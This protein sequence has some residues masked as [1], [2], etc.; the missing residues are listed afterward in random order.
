M[1]SSLVYLWDQ[2]T[3][4]TVWNT[5]ETGDIYSYFAGFSYTP[6]KWEGRAGQIQKWLGFSD[7]FLNAWIGLGNGFIRWLVTELKKP[8]KSGCEGL[9][10]RGN[11]PV[12]WKRYLSEHNLKDDIKWSW[13]QFLWYFDCIKTRFCTR[14]LVLTILPIKSCLIILSDLSI[15]TILVNYFYPTLANQVSYQIIFFWC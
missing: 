4:T 9:N 10:V 8:G 13:N 7:Q 14:P 2:L 6:K 12:L 11:F 5:G 1:S 15:F 3:V